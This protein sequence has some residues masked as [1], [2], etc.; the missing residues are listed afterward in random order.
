M[1]FIIGKPRSMIKLYCHLCWAKSRHPKHQTSLIPL[2]KLEKLVLIMWC[3]QFSLGVGKSY[4]GCGGD[5][6]G[7]SIRNIHRSCWFHGSP[8]LERSLPRMIKGNDCQEEF[9]VAQWSHLSSSSHKGW[10]FSALYN[11]ELNTIFVVYRSKRHARP[12]AIIMDFLVLHAR[13]C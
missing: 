7:S 12:E 13:A 6:E 4:R 3:T 8:T 10:A 9:R 2:G 1:I 11:M 5:G